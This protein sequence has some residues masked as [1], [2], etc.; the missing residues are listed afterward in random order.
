MRSERLKGGVASAI[1]FSE[2]NSPEFVKR[3]LSEIH[4]KAGGT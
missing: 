2:S 3:H 4:I 1:M